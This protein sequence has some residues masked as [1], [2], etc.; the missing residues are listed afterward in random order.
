MPAKAFTPWWRLLHNRVATRSWC[1]GAKFKLVLSPGCA[2]CG[3]ESENLYHFVV[4][5]L[6]KSFFWRDVVSL[7]SLQELL[8]SE[9]SIWLALTSFCSGDDLVVI[10]EE[11][12][13]ALGAAYS[14]LWKYHWRCVIDEE[15]WIASAAINLVRQDHGSLFSSLSLARDQAGTLVL[16]IPIL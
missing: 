11:V 12:L 15:P 3:F 7:L 16:P 13:V 4:G 9:A 1:Y 6:H 10:D 8:P 5:C 14:T 2:L